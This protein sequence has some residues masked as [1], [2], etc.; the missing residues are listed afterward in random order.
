M[1]R[2]V[3]VDIDGVLADFEGAFCQQF[4]DERRE[5]V[6]LESRYPSKARQINEFLNDWRVYE[7][8][9]PIHIGLDICQYLND[10]HFNVNIVT[11]RPLGFESMTRR[12]LKRHG[13]N[14]M[15]FVSDRSKT[16]R[17]AI[18]KPLC[19]VDDLFSV[20]M[21]LL[22]HNIPTIIVA[23]PWNN[24]ISENMTRISNLDG[25]ISEFEGIIFNYSQV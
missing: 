5:L 13:V 17:I 25:F 14:F 3:V 9:E 18:M 20:H 11:A 6:N 4:G 24:Y 19:A 7:N 2:N 1:N 16:G 21:T 23:H 12:W 15:T 22:H 10:H 8:L